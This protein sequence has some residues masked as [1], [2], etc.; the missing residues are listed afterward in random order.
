MRIE[1]N[2][3]I[4]RRKHTGG[5]SNYLSAALM[6]RLL[7]RHESCLRVS[8]RKLRMEKRSTYGYLIID[9]I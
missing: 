9:R 4:T 2:C 5:R 8:L 7:L 6:L 1:K 3:A